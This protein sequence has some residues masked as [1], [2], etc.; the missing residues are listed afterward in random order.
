MRIIQIVGHANSGKTTFIRN[1]IPELKKRG[2]V[3]VIK[4]LA[5]HTY[6]LEAGTDT[7]EFF[8]A[9]ADASIGIDAEKT[10]MAIK[11]NTLDDTLIFL[12]RLGMD[13]A[14]IEG[15]KKC[16]YPKIVIGY[17]SIEKSV[18]SNPSIG[19]VLASLDLFENFP[20]DK[21]QV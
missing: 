17:L 7:T 16:R 19:E 13:F 5:D 20:Q 10:V 12:A 11:K 6:N 2:R 9:G 15:Y 3:A 18:L 21:N 8:D 14:I 4:H 1:L